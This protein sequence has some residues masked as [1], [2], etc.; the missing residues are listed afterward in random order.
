M[1][2]QILARR[3]RPQR[4]A[5]VVGQEPVVRALTN[6]LRDQRIAQ[7]YLFSGIRGVG[8]TSVARILAKALN[9]T[10]SD[11]G[12]PCNNCA[13][14]K[15]ITSGS[16]I[17]VVEV[18][19]AT[20][21]KVDQIR[22]LTDGLQ[23]GPSGGNYKVVILDEVHRLSRQ[24]FD[25]LLKIVE[26]PPEHLVFIFATTD[27]DAVPA[28]ILSRCQEFSFRRVPA[29]LL[30][31]H[32]EHLCEG[33]SLSA[34][35]GSLRRIAR[36]AE[37]SVRDA[38]ALLDQMATLGDGTIND[39]EV[40]RLLGGLDLTALAQ[41]FSLVSVG[42]SAAVSAL[43][44][45]IRSTGRDPRRIYTEL[46]G[47]AREALHLAVGVPVESIDLPGDEIE[48]LTAVVQDLGYQNVL[49]LVQH[50]LDSELL[51]RQ[52][53][54]P[55]LAFELALLRAAELPRL[56]SIEALLS[57]RLPGGSGGSATLDPEAK[58]S[59]PASPAVETKPE[60]PEAG[61][62]EVS[63][64]EDASKKPPLEKV[65]PKKTRPKKVQSTEPVSGEP[66]P[67]TAAQGNSA[68]DAPKAETAAAQQDATP[69]NPKTAPSEEQPI[70][71]P[72]DL[73]SATSPL[74][75][76][77]R[78]SPVLEGLPIE[79]Q[80]LDDQ[81]LEDPTSEDSAFKHLAA[82]DPASKPS[83]SAEASGDVVLEVKEENPDPVITDPAAVAARFIELVRTSKPSL[84]SHLV[85]AEIS[86][87]G[88][89]LSVSHAPD[90]QLLVR[91]W[92]RAGNQQV[93]SE[94]V[95]ELLGASANAT[96]VEGAE[97]ARPAA[98]RSANGNPG[99]EPSQDVLG[100]PQVQT[101]LDIFNGEVTSVSRRKE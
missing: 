42:D 3:S 67:E 16:S 5:E 75:N 46:L 44:A 95:R 101:V 59:S 88:Q 34:A 72:E 15:E 23:Y 9:C 25:A 2:Y 100:H 62:P 8:K 31:S 35:A 22:D 21:S 53:D 24:A 79:E 97:P 20:Y 86:I 87:D 76:R 47:Y 60:S 92:S 71:L 11:G 32:L 55:F 4:F 37:G 98:N 82:K 81:P 74:E 6:A 13:N 40:A 70:S 33:E 96:L 51:L 65:P 57:G 63:L 66:E 77:P 28:T 69:E 36:A 85:R 73:T 50:L 38:V 7:A 27:V 90:D 89:R 56:S 48:G 68:E 52:V 30:T 14:C 91:A 43:V 49:R 54:S 58:A 1:S 10:D 99:V 61:S 39:S 19:A 12:E 94:A 18:D 93:V 78:E 26:E 84:A 80:A 17:D 45:E 64:N 29:D 41:L 83:E